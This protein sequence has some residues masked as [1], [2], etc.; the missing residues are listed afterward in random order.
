MK[1]G[2]QIAY[3]PLHANGDVNHP[4]VE[5]GFVVA[6]RGS[7]HFCR[8]WRKGEPGALRT[9]ANS[10]ASPTDALV[11]YKSV[12]QGVVDTILRGLECAGAAG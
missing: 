1:P 2:T 6:D 4:D 3:V 8:Y 9:V 10:E 7:F 12:L 11:E 5:F